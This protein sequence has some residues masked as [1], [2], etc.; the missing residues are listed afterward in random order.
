M[1]ATTATA[2]DPTA[3]LNQQVENEQWLRD[4]QQQ[5]MNLST[6]NYDIMSTMMRELSDPNVSPAKMQALQTMMDQRMQLVSLISNLVRSIGESMR[7]IINN[8][9]L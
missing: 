1:Q 9:R 2:T 7:A 5:F 3:T 8:L 4:K 6:S